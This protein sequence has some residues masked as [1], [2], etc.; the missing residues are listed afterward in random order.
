MRSNI[1]TIQF[2]YM[3][4]QREILIVLYIFLLINCFYMMHGYKMGGLHIIYLGIGEYN[5]LH[6]R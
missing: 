1:H 3:I 6:M 5:S 2:I 4:N